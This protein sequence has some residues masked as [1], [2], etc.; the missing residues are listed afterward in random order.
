VQERH[1][2]RGRWSFDHFDGELGQ[3]ILTLRINSESKRR[4]L[5]KTNKRLPYSLSLSQTDISG[6]L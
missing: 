6:L 5:L 3:S 1:Y 2:F 4:K